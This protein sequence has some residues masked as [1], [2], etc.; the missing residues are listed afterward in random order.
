MQ[1]SYTIVTTR[2]KI[3]QHGGASCRA[4][5][6]PELIAMNAIVGS[7]QKHSEVAGHEC[8]TRRRTYL[9]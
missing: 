7:K 8:I 1:P 6:Y 2:I 3:H 9:K 5:G 4:I